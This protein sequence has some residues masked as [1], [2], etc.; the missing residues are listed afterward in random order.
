M[1][2]ARAQEIAA[3]AIE[4]GCVRCALL[5]TPLAPRSQPRRSIAAEPAGAQGVRPHGVLARV[6]DAAFHGVA[7][8][9]TQ[10]G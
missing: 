2:P 9:P 6:S 10:P 7:S 1:V 8:K 5:I 4:C 3:A